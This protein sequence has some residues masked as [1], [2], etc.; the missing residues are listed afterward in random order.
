MEPGKRK[1][2]K[3]LFSQFD[4]EGR[5]SVGPLLVLLVTKLVTAIATVVFPVFP[6]F[7]VC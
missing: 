7:E 1:W 6:P 2:S 4:F 5:N 3:K